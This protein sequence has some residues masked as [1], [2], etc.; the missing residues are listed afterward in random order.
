[1]PDTRPPSRN[2]PTP[3]EQEIKTCRELLARDPKSAD[4][5]ARLGAL[6]HV[7][8]ELD[9]AT[10]FFHQAL[11]IEPTHFHALSGLARLS[12]EVGLLEEAAGFY[13]TLAETCPE[14]ADVLYDF[15]NL[16]RDLRQLPEAVSVFQQV[17]EL[18]PADDR[19]RHLLRVL[20]GENPDAPPDAYVRSLFDPVAGRFDHH[21][22]HRLKYHAPENL[23]RLVRSLHTSGERFHHALDLG[24]GT[25]LS[26]L[27][28]RAM[29]KSLT[30][31]D[32]AAKMIARA[33]LKGVYDALAQGSV[34]A[35]L[36]TTRNT[37][38]LFIAT[39]V[40]IY[41][42][43]LDTLF[44]KVARRAAPGAWFVFSTESVDGPDFEALPTGRYAHSMFYIQKL[45]DRFNFTVAACQA[46]EIREEHG[47]PV[48]GHLFTLKTRT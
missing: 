19:A 14:R 31:V 7:K 46:T 43:K 15:G 16:L 39:D 23:A 34:D 33:Q 37:Y 12:R 27:A 17:L 21:L 10:R 3:E 40:L 13:R 32:L 1:M 6:L 26:G 29:T 47:D 44:D 48:P 20:K 41:I 30:G 36:D 25:G 28:F 9:D 18:N 4:T 2:K 22:V 8:G 5:L 42:G 38:D 45:A 24:C 35:F 11:D